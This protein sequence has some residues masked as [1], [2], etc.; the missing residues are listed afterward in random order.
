M[1]VE[2]VMT[3]PAITVGPDTLGGQAAELM[4]S[5]R[6]RHLPV[7]VGGRLVGMLSN[8]D[9]TLHE[10]HRVA[11]L[12]CTD[13]VRVAPDT[14]VEVAAVLLLRSGILRGAPLEIAAGASLAVVLVVAVTR[15]RSRVGRARWM[16]ALTTGAVVLA[17][18]LTT[19]QLLTHPA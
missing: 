16:L 4:L 11:E 5:H 12:M 17:G 18:L 6:F 9:V 1:L 10:S 19:V 2:S 3:A 7:Q 14:P 8:R 13:V 15:S